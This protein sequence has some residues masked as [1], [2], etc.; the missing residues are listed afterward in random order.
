MPQS[1]SGD[2]RERVIGTVEAG[3][4]R[5]EAAELFEISVSSA[6]RWVQRWREEGSS[7]PKPRGGSCSA[8]ENHAKRIL[9]LAAAARFRFT[10]PLLT[11][12]LY[13]SD[14]RTDT[15]LEQLGRLAS[16]R[17]RFDCSDY[18]LTQV[19]RV[20]L[21]HRWPPTGESMSIDL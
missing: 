21:W 1:Y 12:S 18:S 9:A 20:R 10:R 4:S 16:R 19:T 14:G 3:A 7:E 15:D 5:R 11:P 6:I 2:L 13:P 17:P 8:L